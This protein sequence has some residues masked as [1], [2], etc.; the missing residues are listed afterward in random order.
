MGIN[1]SVSAL[2]TTQSQFPSVGCGHFPANNW[3]YSVSVQKC[4]K[5]FKDG[6][7]EKPAIYGFH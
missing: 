6:H 1:L 4:T 5:P 2:L 7:S 3:S